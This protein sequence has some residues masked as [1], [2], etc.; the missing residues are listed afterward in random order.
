M[1]YPTGYRLVCDA[2]G[3]DR[4]DAMYI[5]LRRDARDEGWALGCKK[6]GERAKRGGKDYC[7]GCRPDGPS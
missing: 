4:F 5:K 7:P 3:E 1:I 2:C 6:N